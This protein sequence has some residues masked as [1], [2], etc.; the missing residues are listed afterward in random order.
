M[1]SK[2]SV[3]QLSYEITGLA[4]KVHKF[5]TWAFGIDVNEIAEKATRSSDNFL[6]CQYN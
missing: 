3:T 1:P 2:K 5:R 4:I 6:Y